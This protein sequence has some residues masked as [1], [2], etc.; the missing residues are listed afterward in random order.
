MRENSVGEITPKQ[1][2][3][4]KRILHKKFYDYLEEAFQKS[5]LAELL[6]DQEDQECPKKKNKRKKNKKK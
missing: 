1:M 4:V 2:P 6:S 5:V 3:D